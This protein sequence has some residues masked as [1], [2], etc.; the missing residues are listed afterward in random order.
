MNLACHEAENLYLSDEVLQDL[1]HSWDEAKGLIR[2][3]SEQYGEKSTA[4]FEAPTWDRKQVDVKNLMNE[5]SSILDSKPIHWT[6]RVGAAIGRRRPTGQLEAF[7]GG[8]VVSALWG[9]DDQQT[10]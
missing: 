3:R 8:R 10:D 7:L 6:V 1:G 4:L 9:T 5:I 2:E